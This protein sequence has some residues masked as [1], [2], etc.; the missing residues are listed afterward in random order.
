MCQH[1]QI[2]KNKAVLKRHMYIEVYLNLEEKHKKLIGM[3]T[4]AEWRRD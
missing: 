3:I 2:L 4:S 1:G